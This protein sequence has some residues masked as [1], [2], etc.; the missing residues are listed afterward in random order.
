[1]WEVN[2]G[3]NQER[4]ESDAKMKQTLHVQVPNQNEPCIQTRVTAA[5]FKQGSVTRQISCKTLSRLF[6]KPFLRERACT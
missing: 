1:M 3:G 2:A 6:Q 4:A 5:C